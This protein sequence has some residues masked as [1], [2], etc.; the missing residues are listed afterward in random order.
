MPP[1]RSRLALSIAPIDAE[2]VTRWERIFEVHDRQVGFGRVVDQV[3]NGAF[4]EAIASASSRPAVANR[5]SRRSVEPVSDA[6]GSDRPKGWSEIRERP[7]GGLAARANRPGRR[8]FRT[9]PLRR[10]P[11]ASA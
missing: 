4:H 1:T 3:V 2:S 8:R 10:P 5:W 11:T 9:S 7:F 6:V